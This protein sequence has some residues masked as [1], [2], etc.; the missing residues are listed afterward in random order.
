MADPTSSALPN[1]G[2]DP[3]EDSPPARFRKEE[4]EVKE[5]REKLEVCL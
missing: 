5:L 4:R 3:P 2:D 1:L